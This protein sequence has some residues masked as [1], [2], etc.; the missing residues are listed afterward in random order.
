MKQNFAIK[1]KYK[2]AFLLAKALGVKLREA[3]I[4]VLPVSLIVAILY[5]TPLV[6]LT[7]TEL[8]VFLVS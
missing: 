4:S 7:D 6:S 5:F 2:G 8:I 1:T 3:L